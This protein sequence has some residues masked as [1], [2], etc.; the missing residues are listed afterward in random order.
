MNKMWRTLSCIVGLGLSTGGVAQQSIGSGDWVFEERRDAMSD[1]VAGFASLRSV[2]GNGRLVLTCRKHGKN[3]VHILFVPNVNLSPGP[4]VA[5]FRFDD[6]PA[7]RSLVIYNA[8]NIVWIELKKLLEKGRGTSSLRARFIDSYSKPFDMAFNT[9][10]LQSAARSVAV[11][12]KD[13][14]Q[15]FK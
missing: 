4:R 3:G 2:E 15:N 6:R 8:D 5:E 14:I 12:C 13:P 10:G 7:F 11:V 1:F 9:S